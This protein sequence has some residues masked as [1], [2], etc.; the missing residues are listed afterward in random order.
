MPTKSSRS[1]VRLVETISGVIVYE[2]WVIARALDFLRRTHEKY[3]FDKIMSH[4]FPFEQINEAFGF[5]EEG[6][7]IRVGLTF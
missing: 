7:A 6:G 1:I 5:A 2:G 4:T 3:P